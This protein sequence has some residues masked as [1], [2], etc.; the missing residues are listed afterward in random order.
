M[1]FTVKII[2]HLKTSLD[3]LKNDLKKCPNIDEKGEILNLLHASVEEIKMSISQSL[4]S[5]RLSGTTRCIVLWKLLAL[6]E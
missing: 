4:Q 1:L 3:E 6:K 2:V 5:I